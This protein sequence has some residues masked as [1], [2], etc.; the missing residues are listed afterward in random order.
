MMPITTPAPP[1]LTGSHHFP[2]CGRRAIHTDLDH[3]TPWPTGPTAHHNLGAL[4]RRH[5]RLKQSPH[6]HLT[7]PSPG[8]FH[9]TLPTGHTYDIAPPD[10]HDD[11]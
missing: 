3:T 7:Q 9:W 4:C 11:G 2:G 10:P 1:G 8:H 5:H 6:V